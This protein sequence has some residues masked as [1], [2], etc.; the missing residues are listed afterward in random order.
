MFK[1]VVSHSNDPDTSSA[2]ADILLQLEKQLDGQTP[3]AGLLF[4]AIDFDHQSLL[5][6]IMDAWPKLQLIGCTT[7]GEVSSVLAFQQDSVTLMLFC[8]DNSIQISAGIGRDVSSDAAISTKSAITQATHTLTKSV[9]LCIAVPE[10]LA[11]NSKDILDGLANALPEGVPVVG[12]LAADR[13]QFDTTY[14]FHGRSLYSNTVPVLLFSGALRCAHGVASGWQP[15]GN[16]GTVTRSETN[17]VYEIDGKPALS[18]YRDYLGEHE[19]SSNYPLAVFTEGEQFYLRAP[20]GEFDLDTGSVN[21]FAEVPQGAKVQMS[22]SNRDNILAASRESM[23]Q[24]I[25]AYGP[26][27]PT[28]ALY[29]S[30]ASR[31]Q[32]LGTRTHEEYEQARDSIGIDVP[33]C[34]F[35]TNGEISPMEL[36]APTHFHNETFISLLI[37]PENKT[38][39]Q[40]KD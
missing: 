31:R 20:S 19:P 38:D 14:Q 23:R 11:V 3:T 24:A 8:A 39:K 27:E 18:Y 34:G 33:S 1:V 12:G 9:R 30:C 28:A 35:Y 36:G 32:L 37:G 15:L 40:A 2:T 26:D 4:A 22:Q 5:N 17:T 7:D 29:F 21:F 10:S 25:A 6:D 16:P 13:W